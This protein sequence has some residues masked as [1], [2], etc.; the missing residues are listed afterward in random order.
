MNFKNWLCAS[1]L[2][3]CLLVTKSYSCEFVEIRVHENGQLAQEVNAIPTTIFSQPGDALFYELPWEAR[4][5]FGQNAQ[6]I[7]I[8]NYWVDQ[9]AN[10]V[11]MFV[12]PGGHWQ[13]FITPGERDVANPMPPSYGFQI[14]IFDDLQQQEWLGG[15]CGGFEKAQAGGGGG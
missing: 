3:I 11:V 4:V 14:E 15:Y 1:V 8:W 10:P 7:F 5:T 13:A 2:A 6:A 12:Q 9:G